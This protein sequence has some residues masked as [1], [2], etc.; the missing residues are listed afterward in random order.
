MCGIALKK[1]GIQLSEKIVRRILKQNHWQL[2][3]SKKRVYSAYQE[4]IIPAVRSV[5]ARNSH[6]DLPNEKWLTDI[7]ES[8]IPAGKVYLSPMI[9]CFDGMP[10]SWRIGA[11]PYAELVNGMPD[12]AIKGLKA[13]ERPAI[14]TD[15]GCH[16]R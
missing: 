6:A 9:D 11:S 10:V 2:R 14:H 3:I 15:I 7:T 4:E 5:I 8:A 16:Y 1:D 12:D 13:G